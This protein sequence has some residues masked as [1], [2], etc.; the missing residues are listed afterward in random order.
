VQGGERLGI[1]HG[2]PGAADGPG[3]EADGRNANPRTAQS[4]A[5]D[6]GARPGLG[7]GL[8]RRLERGALRVSQGGEANT[9]AGGLVADDLGGEQKLTRGNREPQRE[10]RAERHGRLRLDE[11]PRGAEVPHAGGER[12]GGPALAFDVAHVKDASR[13]ATVGAFHRVP[14]VVGRER[15]LV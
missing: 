8:D 12:V 7:A 11:G 4:P 1:V 6:T 9:H 3:A 2:P 13:A 15:L 5:L 10:V 14:R